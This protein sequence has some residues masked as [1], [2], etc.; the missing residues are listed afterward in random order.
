MKRIIAILALFAFLF[1]SPI[2]ADAAENCR[3]SVL[4]CPPPDGSQYIVV[5]CD[6]YDWWTWSELLC[7]VALN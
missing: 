3:T 6:A 1:V 2:I 4:T 5:W 7:G